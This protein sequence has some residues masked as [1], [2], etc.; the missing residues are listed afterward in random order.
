MLARNFKVM[1]RLLLTFLQLRHIRHH[2]NKVFFIKQLTILD[3][4]PPGWEMRYDQVIFLVI[5]SLK[6]LVWQTL[7]CRSR[8]EGDDVSRPQAWYSIYS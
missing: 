3:A 1:F 4:L 2:P 7:F 6:R 8:D 5:S